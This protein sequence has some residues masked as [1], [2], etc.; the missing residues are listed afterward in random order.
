VV[1]RGKGNRERVRS[2]DDTFNGNRFFRT[3]VLALATPETSLF[4][5]DL[6]PTIIIHP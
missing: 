3:Y 1:E 2:G 4:I 6:D 5:D